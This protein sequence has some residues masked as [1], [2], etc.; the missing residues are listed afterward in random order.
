[1][2]NKQLVHFL[3]IGKTGGSAIKLAL[4]QQINNSRYVFHYRPHQITLNDVPEGEK[5][6]FFLRDP[7]SRFISGF[8]SRLRQGRPKYFAPWSDSE[9]AAFEHFQTPRQLA[10]ALSSDNAV[11][12]TN[13]ENAMNSIQHVNQ[14]YWR[15]FNNEAYLTQRQADIFFIGCQENLTK[16]FEMLKAKLGVTDDAKLPDDDVEAHRN[17][18]NLDKALDTVAIENL[19]HWYK[20]DYR[21]ISLCKEIAKN[22]GIASSLATNP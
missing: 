2:Q 16:D 3:H 21:F 19:R 18:A 1:M 4:S 5:V 7:M 20:E 22:Q 17:P 12:K 15:W 9:K 8:Y 14:S 13:A 10:R 11:Q 6:V